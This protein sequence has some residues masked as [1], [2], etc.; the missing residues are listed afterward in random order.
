MTASILAYLYTTDGLPVICP[1]REISAPDSV[2]VESGFSRE[3]AL[4]VEL[5]RLGEVGD[6]LVELSCSVS[7]DRLVSLYETK[8]RIDVNI[9]TSK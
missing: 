7:R 4:H 6:G 1:G 5:E 3:R 2:G 8:V 9:G